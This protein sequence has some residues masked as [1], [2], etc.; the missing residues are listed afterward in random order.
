MSKKI[1][2]LVQ[3]SEK[4]GR[5]NPKVIKRNRWRP[6]P[7]SLNKCEQ[8]ILS[9]IPGEL[10]EGI[11]NGIEGGFHNDFNDSDCEESNSERSIE[12][13]P[14]ASSTPTIT[15]QSRVSAK[16]VQ[17]QALKNQEELLT[18]NRMALRELQELNANIRELVRKI[19][20]TNE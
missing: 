19:S 18:I 20:R 4:Q 6:P 12:V 9:T 10:I 14:T 16:S 11:N 17:A 15:S 8:Q 5:R 2:S 13:L 3:L 1:H 7:T